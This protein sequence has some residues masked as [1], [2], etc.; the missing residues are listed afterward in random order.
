MMKQTK[1]TKLMPNTITIYEWQL[2]TDHHPPV[3]CSLSSPVQRS[4]VYDEFHLGFD[5][6]LN[7]VSGSESET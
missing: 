5:P 2:G 6:A 3:S 1:R 4:I 7:Q